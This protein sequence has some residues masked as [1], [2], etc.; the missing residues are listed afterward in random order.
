M[1]RPQPTADQT[2]RAAFEE[3]AFRAET[4]A[5]EHASVREPLR[6]AASLYR[7]QGRIAVRLVAQHATL[8][9]TGSLA[10]DAGVLLEALPALWDLAAS[11]PAPLAELEKVRSSESPVLARA[12]LLSLW[13]GEAPDDWLTRCALRPYLAALLVLGLKPDRPRPSGEDQGGLCPFC[14]GA[15]WVGSRRTL[16]ETDGATRFLHCALCGGEWKVNRIHCP[17]CGEEDPQKLPTFEAAAQLPGA[18][19]EACESCQRY[20]KSIDRSTDMRRVPE[21]DDLATVALDFWA[22]EQGLTRGEP[23]LLGV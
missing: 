10:D 12:R 21:I 20:V 1:T 11:G 5:N 14:A 9:L 23:G 15:P 8:P 16:P 18:R 6:F 7:A 13:S 2:L 3:Y 22:V 4:L 17:W 19:I